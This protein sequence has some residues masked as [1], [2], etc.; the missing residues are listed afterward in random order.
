MISLFIL[1]FFCLF[2]FFA[3]GSPVI[4]SFLLLVVLIV[5]PPCRCGAAD[6]LLIELVFSMKGWNITSSV[7]CVLTD[8]DHRLSHIEKTCVLRV[9]C[10]LNRHNGVRVPSVWSAFVLCLIAS[11]SF[12]VYIWRCL[13]ELGFF[14]LVE[15]NVSSHRSDRGFCLFFFQKSKVGRKGEGRSV[16]I[17][18]RN[19]TYSTHKTTGI[20][21]ALRAFAWTV[22]ATVAWSDIPPKCI[23]LLF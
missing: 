22:C 8:F 20:V 23:L 10:C 17:V 21:S 16:L 2:W 18:G 6:A 5:L 15:V 13:S 1:L 9:H 14:L 19:T 11:C 4:T 7:C 12:I 3:P